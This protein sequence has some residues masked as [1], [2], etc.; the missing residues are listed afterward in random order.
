MTYS[1]QQADIDTWLNTLQGKITNI[2]QG[3]QSSENLLGTLE[4][5]KNTNITIPAI[6][7]RS[8]DLPKD[9]WRMVASSGIECIVHDSIDL[10]TEPMIGGNAIY[11]RFCIELVQ[12]NTNLTN[13][14]AI[15]R[16]TNN[17][18]LEVLESPLT[19][20]YAQLPEGEVFER[21]IVKATAAQ[22][23]RLEGL[24]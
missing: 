6:Y 7:R 8:K 21:T 12:H 2:L 10:K 4:F 18:Y 17:K 3:S 15:F 13:L 22:R 23:M 1:I 19:S 11:L 5:T 16:L 24:T 20:P 14:P 9:Q